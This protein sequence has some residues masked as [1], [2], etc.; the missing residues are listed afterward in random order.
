MKSAPVDNV[1]MLS[2]GIE[3]LRAEAAAHRDEIARLEKAKQ[4][5]KVDGDLLRAQQALQ[6]AMVHEA[7]LSEEMEVLDIACFTYAVLSVRRRA[8]DGHAN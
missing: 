2:A 3:R 1:E 6:L 8:A 4:T 7:V 5:P